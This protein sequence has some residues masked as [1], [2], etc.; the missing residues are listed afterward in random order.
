[1]ARVVFKMAE[2]RDVG[3]WREVVVAAVFSLRFVPAE[4][5]LRHFTVFVA[6]TRDKRDITPSLSAFS[7]KIFQ[8]R[9]TFFPVIISREICPG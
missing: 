5:T 3:N 7:G 8:G 2:T 6:E 4:G 1:M 9:C